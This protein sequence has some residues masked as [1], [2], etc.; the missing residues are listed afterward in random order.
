[1]SSCQ[2]H[3]PDL[4]TSYAGCPLSAKNNLQQKK[5]NLRSS[6]QHSE[7]EFYSY[8]LHWHDGPLSRKMES[9]LY[10]RRSLKGHGLLEDLILSKL[11]V[12]T[13]NEN[14]NRLLQ[15]YKLQFRKNSSKT[16]KVRQLF[17]VEHIKSNVCQQLLDEIMATL[18]ALDEKRRKKQDEE[19]EDENYEVQLCIHTFNDTYQTVQYICYF[20]TICFN[21]RSRPQMTLLKTKI[22]F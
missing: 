10:I 14:L 12:K 21:F 4:A 1:M 18:E 9:N 3:H 17:S 11:I 7:V 8:S 13:T 19:E 5:S 6:C 22:Q 15:E 20:N 2:A 16:Q